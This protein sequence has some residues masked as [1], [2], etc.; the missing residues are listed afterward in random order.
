MVL[1]IVGIE[2]PLAFGQLLSD[3]STKL[4]RIERTIEEIPYISNPNDVALDPQHSQMLGLVLIRGIDIN[5]RCLHGLSPFLGDNKAAINAYA[6]DIVLVH[7]NF[8]CPNWAYTES[9]YYAQAKTESADEE[10]A[11]SST[12]AAS[13]TPWVE[14][15]EGNQSR[16]V[17]SKRWRVRRDLGRA[18]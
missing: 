2:N 8:G 10:M 11:P 15:L 9:L 7:G 4:P 1:A 12:P 16:P 17:G 13:S 6:G 14:V 5:K 18:G 3:H